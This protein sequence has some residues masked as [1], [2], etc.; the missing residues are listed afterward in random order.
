MGGTEVLSLARVPRELEKAL[1]KGETIVGAYQNTEPRGGALLVLTE[2]AVLIESA[3]GNFERIPF[4][5]IAMVER[6]ESK[7]VES[8]RLSL[9]SGE[10]RI[11]PVVG[12]DER[13]K[14]AF[15]FLQFF[16]R[17]LADLANVEQSHQ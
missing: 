9:S 4:R 14:D 7:Q 17:V 11:L 2:E 5:S 10:T 12:G 6:P 8:L 16:D 3:S 1:R 13:T 15:A